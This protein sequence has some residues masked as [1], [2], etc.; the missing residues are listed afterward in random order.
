MFT[1][2]RTARLNALSISDRI[3]TMVAEDDGIDPQFLCILDIE[4]V[5]FGNDPLTYQTFMTYKEQYAIDYV[6]LNANG[7]HDAISVDNFPDTEF[8]PSVK[9]EIIRLGNLGKL[10][11]AIILTDCY[12]Y[13]RFI[14]HRWALYSKTHVER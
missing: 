5:A 2:E 3:K 11:G 14:E 8:E 7:I 6:L 12:T 9:L 10:C 4:P 1:E 13:P